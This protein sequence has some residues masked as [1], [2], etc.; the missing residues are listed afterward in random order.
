MSTAGM[1]RRHE[2]DVAAELAQRR[3]RRRRALGR[4]PLALEHEGAHRLVD[5][6][7]DSRAGAAR[8]RSASAA[9]NAPSRS[10]ST[11]SCAVGQSRPAPATSK[12]SCAEAA[13]ARPRAARRV[14]EPADLVAAR[15]RRSP[16][17]RRCSS[18]CGTSSAR[19]RACRRR[20]RRTSVGER[21]LGLAGDEPPRAAPRPRRLER[22]RRLALV[23]D[24]HEQ[25]CVAL[26]P[27]HEL[28]RLHRVPAGLR[29]V[30][31]GAAA[32]EEPRARRRG[33]G[34]RSA[35]HAASPAGRRSRHGSSHRTSRW[36]ACLLVS[37]FER[38]TLGNGLRVVTAPM[39]QAQSVTV[40]G[41]ARRRLSL[42]DARHER[43]RA[44]RRAHVLQGHEAAPDRA[45]H[46]GRD[47]RD[48]RRVQRLHR[49]GVHGLLRQVRGRAPRRRAR[50]ARRH[51]PQLEVRA[52]GD[53]ARE[54][55]D[56]RGDEHVLRH[57][58]RLHR[59]RLR[60]APLRR[61]AARLGHHR[62]QGDGPRRDARHV[63]RLP[64]PA[65]TSRRGWSSAS[66]AGSTATCSARS[67]SCSATS[68]RPRRAR[69]TRSCS[70]RTNGS[71]VKVFTKQ[72]DQAHI[73]VGVPQLPARASRPL[74]AADGRDRAR[75]RHVVAPLHRGARAPR[76]RLLRLRR[77][78]QLHRRRLAL[79]AGRRRH[80]PH[81]RRGHDDRRRVRADRRRARPRRRAREGAQL[82]EGPLR[83]LAREPA[84]ADHV[85]PPPRGARGRR[86]S[87]RRRCSTPST[88]SPA[89][90][91]SG[92]RAT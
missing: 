33:S 92:S 43:D 18:P 9:T 85:R 21:A 55:R 88:R 67:R 58:A 79:L 83:P 82:R 65:G 50:R 68:S 46:R 24:D 19:P 23:A 66:A 3:G 7:Q 22:E 73:C 89:R 72:S 38:Q 90:T 36:V 47:R 77:Q 45:R 48:R 80:Q 64:R 51:A 60:R 26:R 11:A 16:P 75:R 78:P 70:R 61:P 44:L 35:P 41:D 32:G 40:L 4:P 20:P 8:S 5:R 53:R 31:R 27:E 56:R 69:S 34:G 49:Q 74:R 15:A 81:R 2:R 13:E 59:R 10:F 57:A 30:E 25:L 86:A 62:P 52:R 84:G 1:A 42:R 39:P 17:P 6:G 28:E 14:A 91:C 87:S 12:R 37:A 76:A 71:Q 63:L 54:G 29:R